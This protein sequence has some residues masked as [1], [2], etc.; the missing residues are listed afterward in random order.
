MPFI[1]SAV[2]SQMPKI[3]AKNKTKNGSTIY[4][5]STAYVYA[6]YKLTP[7]RTLHLTESGRRNLDATK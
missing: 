1:S 2:L 3:S 4:N 7:G 5:N 6:V